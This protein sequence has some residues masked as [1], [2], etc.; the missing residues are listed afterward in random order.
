MQKNNVRKILLGL[1]LLIMTVSAFSLIKSLYKEDLP[2]ETLKTM[3]KNVDIKIENFKVTH[4]A[5][6]NKDWEIKAKEAKVK[7]EES[8]IILTDVNVTFK[9]DEN[10]KSTISADTGTINRETNDIQ[11]EGNV[12]FKADASNL[13]GQPQ[14]HNEMSKER[15]A[16]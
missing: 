7:N 15:A 5:L 3:S 2:I 11:L 8:K 13:F 1:I 16:K 12:K 10:Q 6:G 14:K 4:E 9:A